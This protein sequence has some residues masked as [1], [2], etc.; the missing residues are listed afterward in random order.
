VVGTE[1]ERQVST[2]DYAPSTQKRIDNAW[3]LYREAEREGPDLTAEEQAEIE[4]AVDASSRERSQK[5]F[6]RRLD[7]DAPIEEAGRGSELGVHA[8]D[9]GARFI[10]S[11]GYKAI[12][13]P[14]SLVAEH[15]AILAELHRLDPAL[16]AE[17]N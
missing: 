8:R 10:E 13:D 17:A 15:N 6:M 14:S 12:Q 7:G 3:R 16:S 4:R 11:A 2:M 9:P 5:S 1:A